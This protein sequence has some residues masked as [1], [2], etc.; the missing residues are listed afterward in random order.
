MSNNDLF[1]KTMKKLQENRRIQRH[2]HL[3]KESEEP[4]IEGEERDTI[5]IIDPDLSMDEFKEKQ[6]DITKKISETPEG[7]KVVDTQYVGMKIY[8]CPICLSNFYSETEMQEE[9]TCPVCYER[10][11]EFIYVGTVEQAETEEDTERVEQAEEELDNPE[12]VDNEETSEESNNEEEDE[13]ANES[14]EVE[15]KNVINE[16]VELVPVEVEEPT[17]QPE[18]I[19]LTDILNGLDNSESIND[20]ANVI[21]VI[22]DETLQ[23]VA[24]DTLNQCKAE[25]NY[26]TPYVANKISEA[27]KLKREALL[28]ETGEWDNGDADM[29]NWLEDLRRQANE[30]AKQVNGKVKSVTGFDKY[31]GPRAIVNTPKYGDI[32]LW[33]DQEDDTGFSFNAKVAHK[34]WISGGIKQL[35]DLLNGEITENDIIS[36]NKEVLTEDDI[37]EPELELEE[38]E[39]FDDWTDQ[40]II[41]NIIENF[42]TITTTPIQ[43]IFNYDKSVEGIFKDDKINETSGYILDYLSEHGIRGKR[44]EDMLYKLD[45]ELGMKWQE[46]MPEGFEEAIET[47]CDEGDWILEEIENTQLESKFNSLREENNQEHEYMLLDRLKQDCDYFLGNGNRDE[48]CLWAGSVDGQIA[49]MKNLYNI[50]SEKPEWLTMEDIENYEKEMGATILPSSENGTAQK[51][52]QDMLNRS[53]KRDQD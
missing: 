46:Y 52:I 9:Q 37:E 20:I 21:L 33:F 19:D 22:P 31:Q 53:Q 25:Y 34:G 38:P 45:D 17:E 4:E 40:E 26:D 7:E 27:L 5:T 41:D 39:D 24:Q 49:K 47:E 29:N 6:A 2:A 28:K 42:E 50:L 32:E 51:E 13:N 16:E 10:P 11:E 18:V 30:L 35:A 48:K 43:E 14:K 3:V 1:L 36:E 8:Q 23:G 12:D 15:S 44:Q